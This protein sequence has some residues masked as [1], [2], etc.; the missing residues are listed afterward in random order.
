MEDK[1]L[2]TLLKKLFKH[3]NVVKND[4]NKEYNKGKEAGTDL[5]DIVSKLW[6][7]AEDINKQKEEDILNEQS[8][9]LDDKKPK[10]EEVNIEQPII[11]KIHLPERPEH[12]LNMLA[13]QGNNTLYIKIVFFR[14]FLNR[15]YRR[16]IASSQTR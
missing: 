14:N 9:N 12:L 15:S 6:E 16:R 13:Y 3:L 11:K 7:K 4:D 10:L 5:K 1:K 2:K 8:H